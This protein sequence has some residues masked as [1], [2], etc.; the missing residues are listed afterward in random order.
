MAIFTNQATLAFR[1]GTV[2]SNVVTGQI[3]GA[4]TATK[5]AL[6]DSYS[7]GDTVTYVI[8]LIN[9]GT[10]EL[11]GLTVT[12]DLGGYDFGGVTLYPLTYVDGSALYYRN[13]VLQAD[14]TASGGAPLVFSDVSVPANGNAT[15]IYQAT[16]NAAA[17]SDVD[18]SIVNTVNVTGDAISEPVSADETVF[19][20]DTYALSITKSLFPAVVTDNGTIT[21]TF[22][23]ENR[24]N[25]PAIATDNV[26]LTDTFDPVL[27][28]TSVSFNSEE[29]VEGVDYTYNGTTG[30]FS[31]T[32]GR[33]T[34]PAASYVREADGTFTVIPGAVTLVVSGTV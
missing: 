6:Q 10:E 4:L 14:V 21:Y 26:T 9:S 13:G 23:I 12:D 5:T 33:I 11:S 18:G 1:G 19:T 27:D 7:V 3:L 24:G 30:A 22:V 32:E 34:V 28:L 29:W 16:V 20:A 25:T 31:S 2:T 8:S 17:P 15:L